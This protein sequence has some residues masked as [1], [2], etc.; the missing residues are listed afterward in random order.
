MF[1]Q[2]GILRTL[3]FV[4]LIACFSAGCRKEPQKPNVQEQQVVGS[5]WMLAIENNQSRWVKKMDTDGTEFFTCD[6][7]APMITEELLKNSA[8]LAYGKFYGYNQ[9]IWPD[10]KVGL[11][12]VS[13]YHSELGGTMDKWTSSVSAGKFSITVRNSVGTYPGIIDPDI[14]FRLIIIPKA[15]LATT[16]M[17]PVG[18]NPLAQYTEGELRELPYDKICAQAGLSR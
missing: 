1:Y 11:L 18:S 15:A 16:G 8:V 10:E 14:Q 4:C 7:A 5:D 12:P 3:A 9:D 6:F 13:I 17:K 2:N